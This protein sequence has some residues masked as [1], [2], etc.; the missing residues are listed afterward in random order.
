MDLFLDMGEALQ[1]VLDRATLNVTKEEGPE[2]D[3]QLVAILVVGDLIANQYGQ[4]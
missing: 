2:R 3:R 1:V 4:D